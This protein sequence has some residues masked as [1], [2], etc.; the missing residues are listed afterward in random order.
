MSIKTPDFLSKRPA[1]SGTR[2]AGRPE[3]PLD[4]KIIRN[5]LE[6]GMPIR[7]IAQYFNVT[8]ATLRQRCGD[9]I[10]E[11]RAQFAYEILNAQRKQG[12]ENLDTRMLVHM[13]KVHLS[14]DENNPERFTDEAGVEWVVKPPTF[15]KPSTL[16]E[17]ERAE[18]NGEADV[19]EDGDAA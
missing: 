10:A 16:T 7:M 5:F 15:V 11:V 9:L 13:G 19:E 1:L 18:L 6:V 8:D 4:L 17:S 3:K 2:Q 12:V 14:Q